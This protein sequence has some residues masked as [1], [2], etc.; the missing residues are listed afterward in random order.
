MIGML[1]CWRTWYPNRR[2]TIG[3]SGLIAFAVYQQTAAPTIYTL[4]SSELTVAAYTLGPAHP[5]GYPLYLLL[6]RLF[7]TLFPWGDPGYRLNILSAVFG[8]L[9]VAL[10][11]TILLTI[12]CR[13]LVALTAS[14]CLAFSFYFW[15]PALMA[16]VY[17]LHSFLTATLIWLALR[18]R[19]QIQ[20]SN[21]QM[22]EHLNQTKVTHTL[23]L[24]AF[25]FGL[26]LGNHL[27]MVLIVPGLALL[28]VQTAGKWLLRPR[29][30][31]GTLI[32]LAL[33]LSVYLYLPLRA[34]TVTMPSFLG[35][36]TARAF[37]P[38]IFAYPWQGFGQEMLARLYELW[39]NFLGFG[40]SL[41]VIGLFIGWRRDRPLALSLLLIILA[42]TLF[43]AGYRV[44]DKQLMFG[45][46]YLVWAIF[47]GWGFQFLAEQLHVGA[48]WRPSLTAVFLLPPLVMVVVNYPYADLSD[49]WRVRLRAEQI[50]NTVEPQTAV[51][52]RS[53][54]ERTPLEYLQQVE[55]QRT[56]VAILEIHNYPPAALQD[57]V[58][59]Y[60]N[61]RPIYSTVMLPLPVNYQSVWQERCNCYKI[62]RSVE[63]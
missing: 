18:W 31:V 42:N 58:V 5:P 38:F 25:V 28:L 56:D 3:L 22:G 50:M 51:F 63:P 21:R 40:L 57:F 53:W 36:I 61:D 41:I 26:S 34:G 48:Y 23:W 47:L 29:L 9:T 46:V 62:E 37:W 15:S 16:E 4:D 52:V 10:A 49:D 45:H 44:A 14:L 39:G 27:T 13:K 32:A 12:G 59:T 7:I 43:L 60:F 24:L 19:K 55:S 8:G 17:T 35:V 6:G 30:V 11:C 2:L 1:R 33:G 20:Q 54:V